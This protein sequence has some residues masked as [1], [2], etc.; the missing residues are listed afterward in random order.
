[1]Q[2]PPLRP[3]PLKNISHI[4]SRKATTISRRNLLKYRVH[5]PKNLKTIG[6][7]LYDQRTQSRKFVKNSAKIPQTQHV[8][9][10]TSFSLY[11]KAVFQNSYFSSKIKELRAL[12][13]LRLKFDGGLT[14]SKQLK[15]PVKNLTS[16]KDLT[17]SQIYF[18]FYNLK[19]SMEV[20]G[21]Q[22]TSN[23]SKT[24]QFLL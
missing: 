21:L 8:I 22:E 20:K 14:F 2:G 24:H 17:D 9:S 23:S 19:G 3:D 10:S 11:H 13:S 18:I 4:L 15:F 12:S 5:H 6:K 16:L 1:M 7:P